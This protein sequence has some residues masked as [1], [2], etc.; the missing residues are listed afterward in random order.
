MVRNFTSRPFVTVSKHLIM[1]TDKEPYLISLPN[2]F[3]S[4]PFIPDN[5]SRLDEQG[6]CLD[7]GCIGQATFWP[8]RSHELCIILRP[9][10]RSTILNGTPKPTSHFCF[11]YYVSG[12]WGKALK[13][14][15]K[16]QGTRSQARDAVGRRGRGNTTAARRCPRTCRR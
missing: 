14:I 2:A 9:P 15:L 7:N 12:Q 8:R 1:V 10:L 16:Q 4:H 3:G 11:S 13:Q 6:H 5:R